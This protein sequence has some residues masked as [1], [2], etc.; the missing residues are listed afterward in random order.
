MNVQV[1]TDPHGR[2]LWASP[3]LPG[4]VHDIRAARMHGIIDALN[5]AGIP[6]LGRMSEVRVTCSSM[7]PGRS[8]CAPKG[9][10]EVP[11]KAFSALTCNFVVPPAGF[12]P[13]TPA[14]GAADALGGA[15]GSLPW[16]GS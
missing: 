3:A 5:E 13:A 6:L 8:H 1:L 4:A 14:L 15:A 11:R 16:P 9:L 2:L 10:P 7:F 12:E